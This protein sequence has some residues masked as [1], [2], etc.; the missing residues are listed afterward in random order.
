[1][2]SHFSG[3]NMS[4]RYEYWASTGDPCGPGKELIFVWCAVLGCEEKAS[5]E[6]DDIRFPSTFSISVCQGCHERLIKEF[7]YKVWFHLDPYE[8]VISLEDST[9]RLAWIVGERKKSA[10]LLGTFKN[11]IQVSYALENHIASL[12]Y[13]EE[14]ISAFLS[15]IVMCSE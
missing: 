12:D 10:T 5:R 3:F 8:K 13:Q 11:N 1:M 6:Y 4:G 15:S 2:Q 14:A 7:D 9:K